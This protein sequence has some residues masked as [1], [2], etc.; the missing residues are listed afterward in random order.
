MTPVTFYRGNTQVLTLKGLY[1]GGDETTGP[2]VFQN[3]AM[4]T[5]TLNDQSGNPVTGLSGAT[6]SYVAGSEGWYQYTISSTFNPAA[7]Y[8]YTLIVDADIG[9]GH[10]HREYPVNVEVANQ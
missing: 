10:L 4:V 2:V 6:L 9:I 8:N 3:G 1:S 5:V 7:G